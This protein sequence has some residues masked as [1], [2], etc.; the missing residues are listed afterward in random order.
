MAPQAG[1]LAPVTVANMLLSWHNAFARAVEDRKIAFNPCAGV[2][3]KVPR[4]PPRCW[5]AGELAAF[6]E[7]I[8]GHR[9]EAVLWLLL[10]GLRRGDGAGLMW[11][12]LDRAAR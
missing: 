1:R 7:A 8:G 2:H 3:V 4:T 11:G 10:L 9:H 12:D 6:T 5:D